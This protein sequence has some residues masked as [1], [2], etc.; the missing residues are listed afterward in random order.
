MKKTEANKSRATVPL[1]E[2]QFYFKLCF[3]NCVIHKILMW[4][5]QDFRVK[6][7]IDSRYE[8]SVCKTRKKRISL[9][10]LSVRLTRSE[11][12]RQISVCEARKKR[13]SLQN[14]SARL[15]RS[16][17]RYKIS[18]C[19]TREKRVS[20]LILSR[21][22]SENFGPKKR[23]LLLGRISKSDSRVNLSYFP[24]GGSFGVVYKHSAG[25]CWPNDICLPKTLD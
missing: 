2:P 9:Q 11:S 6:I 24:L 13:A 7:R 5:S 21:E 20:L 1:R 14:L 16:E 8:I 12:H 10:N 19:D 3:Q 25:E 17:S 4:F 15:T 23:V 22:S 18:V